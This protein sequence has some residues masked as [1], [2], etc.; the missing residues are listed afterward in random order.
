MLPGQAPCF[1]HVLVNKRVTS[2]GALAEDKIIRL[3]SPRADSVKSEPEGYVGHV[4]CRIP[5]CDSKNSILVV[6]L[7]TG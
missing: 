4:L 1:T 2:L 6:S 7:M 3:G 5:T